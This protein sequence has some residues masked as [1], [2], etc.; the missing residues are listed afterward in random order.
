MSSW[1]WIAMNVLLVD[2][3]ALFRETLKDI[4][5]VRFP[6]LKIE[7][8]SDGEEALEKTAAF[9]PHL[10]FMDVSLPGTSGLEV[11]RRIKSSHPQTVVVILTNYDVL[12]YR[13]AALRSGA[14]CFLSKDGPTDELVDLVRNVLIE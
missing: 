14:N 8:A 13:K 6:S 3:N 4:L 1:Y 5:Q 7:E 2:D 11:T 9:A 10:V 12:E